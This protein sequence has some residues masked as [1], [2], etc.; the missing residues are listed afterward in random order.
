MAGID[1]L[2]FDLPERRLTVVHRLPDA[3]VVA[4]ALAEIGMPPADALPTLP[5]PIPASES[6][7]TSLRTYTFRIEKMD[8]A[9]EEG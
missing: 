6:R 7:A 3:F 8:C 2:E 4:K 1:E 9:T 5:A